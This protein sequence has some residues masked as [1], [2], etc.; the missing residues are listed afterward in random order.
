MAKSSVGRRIQRATPKLPLTFIL[1]RWDGCFLGVIDDIVY[2]SSDLI[3]WIEWD[4]A[5]GNTN[6]QCATQVSARCICLLQN[7][8][9]T[10][11][12]SMVALTYVPEKTE[13][14][15]LVWTAMHKTCALLT[16]Y[17][18]KLKQATCEKQVDGTLTM[19]PGI[20][21][22]TCASIDSMS[23][24]DKKTCRLY[25]SDHRTGTVLS[26]SFDRI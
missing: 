9:K 8:N 21:L 17:T 26:T 5:R 13:S 25:S 14:M 18:R 16:S 23:S 22:S 20:F 10:N 2:Y 11:L 1:Q 7:N 4:V 19:D 6:V 12:Q 24:N 3:H 15:R